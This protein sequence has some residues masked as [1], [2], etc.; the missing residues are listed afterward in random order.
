MSKISIRMRIAALLVLI[1][2]AL[3]GLYVLQKQRKHSSSVYRVLSINDRVIDSKTFFREKNSFFMRWRRDAGMLRKTDEQRMDILVDEIIDRTVIDDFL[4]HKSGIKI[5]PE[6]TKDYINRYIR[7]KYRTPEEFASFLERGE[8]GSE[9]DL[10]KD[11]TLYQLKLHYFSGLAKKAGIIVPAA[12]LD[13]L[14]RKHIEDNLQAVTRHITITDSDRL[15]ARNLAHDLYRQLIDGADFS[16]LAERYSSDEATRSNGGV[17][18]P[19]F[20]SG[21]DSLIAERVFTCKE[22]GLLPPIQTNSGF[23][24][25]KVDRFIR[26]Y[27]SKAEFT[28]MVLMQKFSTSDHFK[29]WLNGVKSG[30]TIKIADPAL[31]AF[32]FYRDSQYNQAGMLYYSLFRKN[33]SEFLLQ[34]AI[35]SFIMAKKWS[36]VI[37]L[38]QIAISSYPEK[39]SFELNKAEGLFRIGKTSEAEN[40]LKNAESRSK[41]SIFLTSLVAETY[42][43]LGL[44]T[45]AERVLNTR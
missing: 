1:C 16:A 2:A 40:V 21:I 23:E 13:S 28:D 29:T 36:R 45:E 5:S 17:Q 7:A 39:I 41:G 24:I 3:V 18:K 10:E 33:K 19:F 31:K 43:K 44:E 26:S 14:Y 32:R 22:G 34:R 27:H 30:V 20:R 12:E 8:Y 6:Q 37:R 11:I 42:R 15:K 35:E 9:R 25:I 38:S 4:V